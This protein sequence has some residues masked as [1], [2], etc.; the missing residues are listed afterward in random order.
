MTDTIPQL[1]PTPPRKGSVISVLQA[2]ARTL[3][4]ALCMSI[5]FSFLLLPSEIID[6]MLNG[7]MPHDLLAATRKELLR[8]ATFTMGIVLLGYVLSAALLRYRRG[9]PSVITIARINR[10]TCFALATPLF[11]GFSI[12]SISK[13]Q[14]FFVIFLCALIA[15]MAGIAAYRFP[16]FSLRQHL[17]APIRTG[18]LRVIPRRYH[19]AVFDRAIHL[20]PMLRRRLPLALAWAMVLTLAALYAMQMFQYQLA[21]HQALKTGNFDLG[22]YVNTMWNSVHGQFLK[23]DLVKGGYHI[24]A[25]FDPIL[26]LLSPVMLFD[27]DADPALLLQATWLALGAIPVFLIARHHLRSNWMATTLSA[28]Y[29][30]YPA[31]HGMTLYEFHSLAL[32]GPLVLWAMYF[33]DTGRFPLYFA[34]LVL[35]LLTREDLSLIMCFVGAYLIVA[36]KSWKAGLATVVICVAYFTMAKLTFMSGGEAYNYDEYFSELM[37]KKHSLTESLAITLFTDPISLLRLGLKE[38]KILYLLQLLVP[39]CMLPLLGKSRLLTCVYGGAITFLVTRAA[40]TDISYQYPTFLYPF[41]FAMTPAVLKTLPDARW[42][43]SFNLQPGRLT[44]A[45]VV[46]IFCSTCCMSYNFGAFH[47]NADF[48][49]GHTRLTRT[50]DD[51]QKSRWNIVKKMK[52]M[53]PQQAS[54]SATE[55]LGPHFAARKIIHRLKHLKNTDYYLTYEP[56]LRDKKLRRRYNKFLRRK[57]HQLIF[58]KDGLKLYARQDVTEALALK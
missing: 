32:A 13:N 23:C 33:I 54:L 26:I 34:V 46:A 40:V 5:T 48:R 27:T 47:D 12:H 38:S 56:D 36:R 45:V 53:V 3:P 15:A 39:L 10:V 8:H 58:E 21:H 42:I 9:I 37:I 35:L 4:I 28:T 17:I 1:A 24:F 25:H 49:A 20:P 16:A 55:S 51:R 2:L 6:A 50:L 11:Y 52:A 14:P 57:S 44:A 41:L 30:L 19:L 29:L 22:V 7:R 18:L 43:A 31:I